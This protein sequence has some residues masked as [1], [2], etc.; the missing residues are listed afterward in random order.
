M[1]FVLKYRV[2]FKNMMP[3]LLI[4]LHSKNINLCKQFHKYKSIDII[5]YILQLFHNHFYF[6]PQ[7]CFL[8]FYIEALILEGTLT[9]KRFINLFM[10]FFNLFFT[11]YTT[12]IVT[13]RT[14]INYSLNSSVI[15]AYPP[16]ILIN[17]HNILSYFQWSQQHIY[18]FFYLFIFSYVYYVYHFIYTYRVY[19]HSYE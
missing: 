9:G 6:I 1:Y 5:H 7:V 14:Y 15:N 16:Y 3:F 18:I 4:S 10:V 11:R 17:I 12:F 19:V 13:F 8:Y 2:F